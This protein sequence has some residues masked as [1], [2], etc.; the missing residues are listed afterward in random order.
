MADEDDIEDDLDASW[1]PDD[2]DAWKEEGEDVSQEACVKCGRPAL[3]GV[4]SDIG[5]VCARHALLHMD[6]SVDA[7]EQ[8]G[9]PLGEE[10]A[11]RAC[12]GCRRVVRQGSD[13]CY[14]ESAGGFWHER[15]LRS[16]LVGRGKCPKCDQPLSSRG[17]CLSCWKGGIDRVIEQAKRDATDMFRH[18]DRGERACAMC[19]AFNAATSTGLPLMPRPPLPAT[20][21]CVRCHKAICEDHST[22]LP[23]ENLLGLNADDVYCSGG[24]ISSCVESLEKEVACSFEDCE[25]NSP[26]YRRTDDY[27]PLTEHGHCEKC[28]AFWCN[29]ERGH[30]RCPNC[31]GYTCDRCG[32]VYAKESLSTFQSGVTEFED[33]CTECLSKAEAEDEEE[34]WDNYVLTEFKRSLES[35]FS[36]YGLELCLDA[37]EDDAMKDVFEQAARTCDVYWE[38]GSDGASIDADAVVECVGPEDIIGLDGVTLNE[39]LVTPETPLSKQTMKAIKRLEA[40]TATDNYEARKSARARRERAETR[41]KGH[42]Q[43][44]RS[45]AERARLREQA[46][47][48]ITTGAYHWEPEERRQIRALPKTIKGIRQLMD[49]MRAEARAKYGAAAKKERRRRRN[50][51]A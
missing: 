46:R 19:L 33:L 20:E 32:E 26:H 12:A 39:V 4:T 17:D 34:T 43:T 47:H 45:R 3:T 15:C 37:V 22:H 38:R 28:G 11:E 51:D 23:A 50:E 35:R 41:R 42:H 44:P 21:Q 7:H 16:A 1:E 29:Q 8:L 18:K 24:F 36:E 48:S 49:R 9:V 40:D 30:E 2:P 5:P 25:T 6:A 10:E 14:L 13:A 31:E 27:D